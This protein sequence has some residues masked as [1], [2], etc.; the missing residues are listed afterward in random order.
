MSMYDSAEK[1]RKEFKELFGNDM[2]PRQIWF[3]VKMMKSARLYCRSNVAFNNFMN[4]VFRGI[5]EFRQVP[6]Q[7]A[8]GKGYT[9]LEIRMIKPDG[10]AGETEVLAD[11]E[12]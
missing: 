5:A 12:E 7:D 9:G 10:T 8:Q 3:I 2:T 4:S 1:L 11:V 6:K